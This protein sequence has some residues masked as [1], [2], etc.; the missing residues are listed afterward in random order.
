MSS[1]SFL[2][3]I[4]KTLFIKTKRKEPEPLHKTLSVTEKWAKYCKENPGAEECKVYD[5]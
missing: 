1:S 2:E 4:F 5:T 3:L